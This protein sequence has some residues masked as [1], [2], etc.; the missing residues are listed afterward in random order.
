MFGFPVLGMTFCAKHRFIDYE[1]KTL[2][3]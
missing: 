3:T 2:K 1:T